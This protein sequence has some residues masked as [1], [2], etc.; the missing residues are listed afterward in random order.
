[1]RMRVLLAALAAAA[2]LVVPVAGADAKTNGDGGPTKSK[3]CKKPKQV[4]FKVKGD[5]VDFAGTELTVD[6]IRANRHA[7]DWLAEFFP[8]SDPT[9]DATGVEKIKFVGVTDDVAP[10][11]VG[12]EDAEVGDRV[13]LK[14]KLALP[15]RGC[16][17]E[18]ELTVKKIKVKRPNDNA[19]GQRP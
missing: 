13:K 17:G 4:G 6:V 5:F 1:M 7:D 9:F 8:S 18:V 11:G 2:L 10:D 15:K 14:A 12:F 3:K 16:E 19:T